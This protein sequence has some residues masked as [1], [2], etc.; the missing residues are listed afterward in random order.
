MIWNTTLERFRRRFFA[1]W[2]SYKSAGI[3]SIV[4]DHSD[5]AVPNPERYVNLSTPRPQVEGLVRIAAK[6][7]QV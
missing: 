4:T 5:A 7:I 6:Q 1:G 2:Q 3:L